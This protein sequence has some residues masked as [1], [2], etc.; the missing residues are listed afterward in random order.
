VL[1]AA[2]V[3]QAGQSKEP[4]V[5]LS[6][7]L[8]VRALSYSHG[9]PDRKVV[10]T[11]VARELL[12]ITV[13]V[14]NNTDNAVQIGSEKRPWL[15]A[16]SLQL[17][18]ER[19]AQRGTTGSKIV[20]RMPSSAQ[21]PT[22]VVQTNQAQT[23]RG[24]VAR[25]DGMPFS[26]GNYALRV[27]LDRS[28]VSAGAR[29]LGHVLTTTI[30]FEVRDAS[31]N[32]ELADAYLQLSYQSRLA[33]RTSDSRRWSERVLTLNNSSIAAILDLASL[34]L[35]ED[36]SCSAAVPLYQKAILLLDTGADPDVQIPDGGRSSFS[37][38]LRGKLSARCGVMR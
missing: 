14:G 20:L 22:F 21:Q 1:L 37:S 23:F 38:V 12:P 35:D 34:S 32:H 15:S 7:T 8:N 4:L 2:A 3:V 33:G 18:Q 16:L 11:D 6:A 13:A 17:S 5:V 29:A 28:T 10:F 36:R 25:S 31:N 9:D 26:P 30:R 19:D 27:S 24:M